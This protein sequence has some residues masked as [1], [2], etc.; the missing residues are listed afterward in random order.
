MLAGSLQS[1]KRTGL[2]PSRPTA[3]AQISL[4]V[5]LALPS[6]ER[7]DWPVLIFMECTAN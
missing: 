2:V 7:N 5:L 4:I 1:G 6:M 3:P